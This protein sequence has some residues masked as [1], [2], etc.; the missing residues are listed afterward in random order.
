MFGLHYITLEKLAIVGF[1]SSLLTWRH[2]AVEVPGLGGCPDLVLHLS[3]LSST[4][5][6]EVEV[7]LPSDIPWPTHT[8]HSATCF[9]N[10]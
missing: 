4:F 7:I 3:E 8:S 5:L 9:N 1:L 10:A 2:C 6:S